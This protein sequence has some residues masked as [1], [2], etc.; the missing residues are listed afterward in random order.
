MPPKLQNLKPTDTLTLVGSAATPG[1]VRTVRLCYALRHP[2]RAPAVEG[3]AEL[4]PM[5]L[6]AGRR[7]MLLTPLPYDQYGDQAASNLWLNSTVLA[8]EAD[9][10]RRTASMKSVPLAD[11]HVQLTQ[12]LR[13]R[14]EMRLCGADRKTPTA[15]LELLAAAVIFEA[16]GVGPEV[17]HVTLDAVSRKEDLLHARI[18]DVELSA[19]GGSFVYVARALP[20]PATETYRKVDAIYPLTNKFNRE[21]LTVKSLEQGN[22]RLRFDGVEVGVFSAMELAKGVNVALLDTPG[23]RKAQRSAARKDGAEPLHPQ[24][25]RVDIIRKD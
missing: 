21:M 4:P 24:P 2:Y 11:L 25:V 14:V 6:D 15:E 5:P 22:Y 13:E 7:R 9:A 8:A 16:L 1:V 10:I 20:L 17:A 18:R 12:I 23:Q 3:V 19:K